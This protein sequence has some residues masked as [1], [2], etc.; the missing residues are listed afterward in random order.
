MNAKELRAAKRHFDETL[1]RVIS[2]H[3]WEFEATTGFQISG[4]QVE[5]NVVG[6]INGERQ[7]VL[8]RVMSEVTL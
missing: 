2:D 7:V 1:S 6:T 3:L 5:V 8:G 4:I